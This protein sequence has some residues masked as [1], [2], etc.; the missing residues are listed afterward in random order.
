MQNSA[1][2]QLDLIFVNCFT[3][4][5]PILVQFDFFLLRETPS[6][7]KEL[8]NFMHKLSNKI[9]KLIMYQLTLFG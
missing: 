2:L 3:K 1:K 9:T 7:K 6:R 8:G 4:Y 5:L